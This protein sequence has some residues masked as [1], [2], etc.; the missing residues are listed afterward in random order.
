MKKLVSLIAAAAMFAAVSGATIAADN[1]PAVYVDGREIFF[2][3]QPAVIKDDRT[4]VPARG[5]FEAMGAKV[6]WDGEKRQVQ[7][8]SADEQTI[9]RLV[10]DDADM[11]VYDMSGLFAALMTGQD[12]HAPET[13][14]TLD[15]PAQIMND[16]TMV[17]LR[18]ISE[19]FDSNV[20][21]DGNAYIVDITTKDATAPAEDIPALSLT[22]SEQ[23]AAAGE[24]VDVFVNVKNLPENSYVSGVSAIVKYDGNAFEFVSATLVNGN[25][26]IEDSHIAA[27]GDY[28]S[29][30]SF[31]QAKAIATTINAET[32]VKSDSAVMKFTFKSINGKEGTFSLGNSYSTKVGVGY[33]VY[34]AT[35]KEDTPVKLNGDKLAIDTTPVVVNAADTEATAVPKATTAPEATTE[36]EA[37]TAPEASEA[38]KAS[39]E[40]TATSEPTATPEA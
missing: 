24:N 17:P 31:M 13:V 9:V 39:A 26:E 25:A 38:P 10:I 6:D 27:V 8:T 32:A 7:V 11:K 34:L 5:V 21:W 33:D 18:A 36:P 30:S 12:F 29:N 4:L 20:E 28:F 16:R 35:Y 23:T 1:N 37:T 2:D 15:V 3:D 14:V 22:V 40:P 19:A